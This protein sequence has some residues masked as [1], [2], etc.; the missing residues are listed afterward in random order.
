MEEK[1]TGMVVLMLAGWLDHPAGT[2][3]E[4]LEVPPEGR[5]MDG[6]NKFTFLGS[7]EGPRCD[8]RCWVAVG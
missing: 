4:A 2:D 3:R 1:S 8:E 7:S 6:M 5:L